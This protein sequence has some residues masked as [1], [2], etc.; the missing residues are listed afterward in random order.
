MIEV[1]STSVSNLHDVIVD[2][3]KMLCLSTNN[4]VGQCFD[5]A[6]NML[7]IQTGVQA[8][9]KATCPR[10]PVFVHCWAYVLNLV[11]QDVKAVPACSKIFDILQMLHVFIEG[12][13]KRHAEY[14]S[15][16]SDVNLDSGPSV[17]QT[18]SATR[19]SAR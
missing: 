13:P 4:L 3:L 11:V 19:W 16:L 9:I 18:L 7:G 12:S 15:C 5:G 2:K 6:S 1:D 8:R 14:S 10:K 17:L